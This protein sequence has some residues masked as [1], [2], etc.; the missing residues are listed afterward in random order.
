MAFWETVKFE[1]IVCFL[2]NVI[3]TNFLLEI[4]SMDD[5]C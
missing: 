2:I 1:G 5:L 3:L 4:K